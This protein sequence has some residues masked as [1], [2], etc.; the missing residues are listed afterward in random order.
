M[1]NYLNIEHPSDGPIPDGWKARGVPTWMRVNMSTKTAFV[2]IGIL[3]AAAQA[4]LDRHDR[5]L[6]VLT[7]ESLYD[8]SRR[9]LDGDA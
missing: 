8:A 5:F 1:Q 4:V 6:G 7:P 9:S 2:A 3:L